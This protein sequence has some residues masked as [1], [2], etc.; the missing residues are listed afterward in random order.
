VR[1][2]VPL[3]GT[4]GER[5]LREIRDIDTEEIRDVLERVDA[6]AW[7]PAVFLRQ[8]GHSLDSRRLGCIIGIMTD[9]ITAKATGAISRTYIGPDLTKVAKAKCLGSPQG[10]IRLSLDEEVHGGLFLAEGIETGLAI[11]QLGIRP[12]WATGSTSIMAKFPVLAGIECLTVFADH[13]L[14]GAGEKAARAAAN[15]WRAFGR[16]AKVFL[17]NELG[18]IND[19]TRKKC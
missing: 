8:E 6:V 16:E 13:D 1:E 9:P 4:D 3:A 5:Y 11:M 10:I 14:N 15:T 19:L 12:V 18:D 17:P 7:H 2:A